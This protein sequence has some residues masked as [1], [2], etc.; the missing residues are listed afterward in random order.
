MKVLFSPSE[1]KKSGGSAEPFNHSDFIFP[2]LFDKRKEVIDRY[3]SFIDQADDTQLSKLFGIKDS[4]KFGTYTNDI[5]TQPT[6]KVIERYS[7]V[8]FEYLKYETLQSRE[9]EYV[10]KNTIIFSNLFGPLYAGDQHLPE[11]KLK[12]G[13][14]IDGFAPEI[15]YKK[16]FSD[17]LDDLLQGEPFLDLRAGFYNKFYKAKTPYTTLK[18]VKNGKVVSHW[19]K[20]YRGIVLRELAINDIASVN[21]FR[22][23][24]IENL[25][26]KEI[27]EKGIHTEIIF[28]IIND[29]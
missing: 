23:M 3:K 17:A 16:H 15:F 28:D 21:D 2:D 13:E 1:G 8:A 29:H 20:A 6:M 19:A 27:Q 9:K 11:Y 18:F 22:K 12:Q 4:S 26:V 5:Y 25:M 14:K 10:D 24:D 7:G